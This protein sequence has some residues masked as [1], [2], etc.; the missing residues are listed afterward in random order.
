MS[1]AYKTISLSIITLL[2]IITSGCGSANYAPLDVVDSVDINRYLGKWHEIAR[3]PNSFQEGCYCTTAEYTLNDDNSI[4]VRNECREDSPSG[5]LDYADG[6]AYIVEGSNNAKLKVS[7]FWPFKGDY[8]IIE[9]DEAHY[10]YA[11]VGT[12]SRE[13][14][15]ILSRTPVMDKQ[16]Y[17]Q[18]V[19]KANAKGFDVSKLIIT[20]QSCFKGAL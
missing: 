16:L 6:T 20:D 7:F 11:V 12:P 5:E 17:D 18:L 15:W 9:L 19:E 13:Y 3:L 14:L 10:K 4:S 8:W 2:I 1:T